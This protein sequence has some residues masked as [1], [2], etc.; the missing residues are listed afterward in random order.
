MADVPLD[1]CIRT[2]QLLPQPTA[3]PMSGHRCH[4]HS[5][6]QGRPGLPSLGLYSPAGGHRGREQVDKATLCSGHKR[7]PPVSLGTSCRVHRPCLA[8]HHS[9][10]SCAP[11]H[12]HGL[13]THWGRAGCASAGLSWGGVGVAMLIP[14]LRCFPVFVTLPIHYLLTKASLAPNCTV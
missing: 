8:P 10:R 6:K 1:A 2:T 5:S 14:L 11:S 12:S 4:I 13:G 3:S 7:L 9:F